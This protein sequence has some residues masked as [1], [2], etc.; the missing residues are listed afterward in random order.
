MAGTIECMGER[1]KVCDIYIYSLVDAAK[2]LQKIFIVL[3]VELGR[4]KKT[5]ND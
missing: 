1:I 3:I 4:R 2:A 5:P